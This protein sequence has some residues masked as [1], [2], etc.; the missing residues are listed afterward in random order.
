MLS[1]H[2]LI[3]VERSPAPANC[4]RP[5]ARPP[6]GQPAADGAAGLEAVMSAAVL[7]ATA[8]RLRD[9]QGLMESLRLLVGTLDEVEAASRH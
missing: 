9:E 7:V 5:G 2:A 4:N 1:S 3:D 6:V 8:F